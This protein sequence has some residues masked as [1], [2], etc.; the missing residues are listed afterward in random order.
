MLGIRFW[1]SFANLSQLRP[2]LSPRGGEKLHPRNAGERLN[3]RPVL[4]RDRFFAVDQL[5]GE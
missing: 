4:N 5:V 3:A 1:R 2:D